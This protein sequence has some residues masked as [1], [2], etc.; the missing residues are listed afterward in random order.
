MN[1]L[2]T[3]LTSLVDSAF[4]ITRGESPSENG[5]P[6]LHLLNLAVYGQKELE[7]SYDE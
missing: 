2:D 5:L 4:P 3:I 6:L 7:D 1:Q